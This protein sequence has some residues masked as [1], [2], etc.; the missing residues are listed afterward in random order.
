MW[1]KLRGMKT[2]WY[3]YIHSTYQIPNNQNNLIFIIHYE[4]SKN[5]SSD[6]GVGR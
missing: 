6:Q 5:W 3:I 4:T 2:F 1:K